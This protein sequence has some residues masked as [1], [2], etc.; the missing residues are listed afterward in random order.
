MSRVVARRLALVLVAAVLLC[1]GSWL[2]GES[3]PAKAED[4]NVVA[5]TVV[6]AVPPVRDAGRLAADP[7][8]LKVRGVTETISTEP[9]VI[10]L[11]DQDADVP[12]FSRAAALPVSDGRAPPVRQ[13]SR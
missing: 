9:V 7:G 6:T 8:L 12:R 5:R 11:G 4:E 3:A 10:G 1:L 13:A 2:G